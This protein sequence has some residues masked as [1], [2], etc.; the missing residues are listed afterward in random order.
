[1][2][3]WLIGGAALIWNLFGFIVYYMQVSATPEQLAAQYSPEQ[4]EFMA[5]T[6]VWATSAFAI[7]VNA[8]VL[9]S[10]FLLL[11]KAWA[12]PLFV[13]SLVAVLVQNIDS[14]VLNDAIAI[15]GTTPAFIQGTVLL[16]AVALL[17]YARATKAKGWIT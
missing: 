12:V 8:G 15:F 9:G 7:A 13:L 11:R 4:I 1:M 6:P 10:L 5:N 3:F 16:I 14:F 2:S 17:L